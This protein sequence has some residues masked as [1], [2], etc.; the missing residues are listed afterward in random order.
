MKNSLWVGF[1]AGVWLII[2]PWIL[3]YSGI[4]LAKWNAVLVGLILVI[5]FAWE[6]FG[7]KE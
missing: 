5:V 2:S 4:S 1:I 7:E 6:I 3:G